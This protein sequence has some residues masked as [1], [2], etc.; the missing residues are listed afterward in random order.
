MEAK[1][2]RWGLRKNSVKDE[3]RYKGK[4]RVGDTLGFLNSIIKRKAS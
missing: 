1:K 3:V 2:P 4:G